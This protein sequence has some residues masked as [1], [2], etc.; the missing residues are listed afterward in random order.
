MTAL[1]TINWLFICGLSFCLGGVVVLSL[2]PLG[3]DCI[4]P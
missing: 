3:S 4:C 1:A 2:M